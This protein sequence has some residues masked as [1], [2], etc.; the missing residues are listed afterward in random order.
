MADFFGNIFNKL[1]GFFKTNNLGDS[2]T[3]FQTKVDE[4][5][6]DLILPY[7]QPTKL[8]A[9][10][11]F[12]DLITLLDPKS[13]NKI[14]VTLSSN[15]DK[16]YTKLQLEQFASSI[17]VGKDSPE[18][19]DD[20]CSDNAEKTINNSKDKVSKKQIC[21]AVAIHY[22]KILNLVAAIL[23]AVNPSDNICLNRLYNLLTL[24]G[25][26]EKEGLSAICNTSNN[27]VKDSI[28]FEPGFRQLLMLYYYH[29]MQDVETDAEKENVRSQ[30]ENMVKTFTTMVIFVDPKLKYDKNSIKKSIKSNKNKLIASMGANA[31]TQ[32]MNNEYM[33][34]NNNSLQNESQGINSTPSVASASGN[35]LQSIRQNI[36][37]NIGSRFENLQSGIKTNI[38]SLKNEIKTEEK[39][40][41]E[42]LMRKINSLSNVIDN[43]KTKKINNVTVGSSNTNSNGNRNTNIG[44][45]TQNLLSN[46]SRIKNAT[47]QT[48]SLNN[49]Q[50]SINTNITP[51]T[52]NA[53]ISNTMPSTTM[54]S[55]TMPA[56]N[57]MPSTTMP[58]SN[59]MPSTTM[60]ASNTPSINTPAS[61]SSTNIPKNITK[62]TSNVLQSTTTSMAPSTTTS[63]TPS[64][65]SNTSNTS[66]TPLPSV[67]N[68]TL[69]SSTSSTNNSKS[70]SSNVEKE[71]SDILNAYN[72]QPSQKGGRNN[73][74]NNNNNNRKR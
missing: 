39:Q 1:K 66:S 35:N 73:N 2:I 3:E 40:N 28:M 45:N 47:L 68:T 69:S 48:S 33:N 63:M 44:V 31:T 57:T 23:T 13:C 38:A 14:A 61:I 5:I 70:K 60:P 64:T 42:E 46:N 11:R 18:C 24:I 27:V 65:I 8:S 54:P 7:A 19:K 55:T 25:T 74:N 20:N 67:S 15:L 62:N 56:S 52:I 36:G 59:T 6:T 17:L 22:V 37:N 12:R 71:V 29:L 4:I 51:S 34:V 43:L 16:N 49:N 21:N 72:K 32:S 26:D 53:T 9:N 30:Y 10:D 58:A 41:I 50:S